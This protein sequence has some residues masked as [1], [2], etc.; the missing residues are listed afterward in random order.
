MSQSLR[1]ALEKTSNHDNDAMVSALIEADDNNQDFIGQLAGEL[2]EKFLGYSHASDKYDTSPS[3]WDDD[4]SESFDVDMSDV[5]D[6]FAVSMAIVLDEE[7][8][9]SV[10]SFKKLHAFAQE[11]D[12]FEGTADELENILRT[13]TEFREKV[14]DKV[15]AYTG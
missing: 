5:K 15:T 11:R 2:A 8:I 3:Y 10:P 12:L 7:I 1:K 13:S 4:A 6:D 9:Q 14:I